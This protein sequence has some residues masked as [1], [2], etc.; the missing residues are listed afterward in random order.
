MSGQIYQAVVELYES[1]TLNPFYPSLLITPKWKGEKNE[2]TG[3]DGELYCPISGII[4]YGTYGTFI[5]RTWNRRTVG[6]LS[7]PGRI[8]N[9]FTYSVE[10]QP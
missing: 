9:L 6:P 7:L 3:G 5:Y 8:Q 1:L 2:E 10:T 4:K